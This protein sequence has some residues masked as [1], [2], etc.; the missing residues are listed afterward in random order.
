MC[1]KD[2]CLAS[3]GLLSD[4]KQWSKVTDF[5][6]SILT[7]IMEWILFSC[8]SLN[9]A[10]YVKTRILRIGCVAWQNKSQTRE[11]CQIYIPGEGSSRKT[12]LEHL[13][14]CQMQNNSCNWQQ[15]FLNE[16][17]EGRRMTVEIISWSISTK[18]WYQAKIKLMS[19]GSAVRHPSVVRHITDWAT[20][21]STSYMGKGERKDFLSQGPYPVCKYKFV[22]TKMPIQQTWNKT[23][24]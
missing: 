21:P 4:D 7:Q 16:S 23:M 22:V 6:Y 5:C 18:V 9:T 19:P 11:I 13:L 1:P 17:V 15:P 12:W 20:R 2:H 3:W 24:S 14:K 8:S 10:F